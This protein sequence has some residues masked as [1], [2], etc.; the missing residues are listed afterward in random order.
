[1]S[2]PLG[3]IKIINITSSFSFSSVQLK[4]QFQLRVMLLHAMRQTN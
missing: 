1:M 4:F 3:L 2:S